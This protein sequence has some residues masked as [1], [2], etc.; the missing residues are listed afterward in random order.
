MCSGSIV[1]AFCKCSSAFLVSNEHFGVLF[2]QKN[3]NLLFIA[4]FF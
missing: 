2:I 1:I 3:N 4:F